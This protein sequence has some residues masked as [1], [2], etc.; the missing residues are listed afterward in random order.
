[1]AP[2]SGHIVYAQIPCQSNVAFLA[3]YIQV[4]APAKIEQ[5]QILEA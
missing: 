2:G 3:R 5:I 4:N 1:V